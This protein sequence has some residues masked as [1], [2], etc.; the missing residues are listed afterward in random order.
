MEVHDRK[1]VSS[2]GVGRFVCKQHLVVLS[3]TQIGRYSRPGLGATWLCNGSSYGVHTCPVPL[4]FTPTLPSC[5][6]CCPRWLFSQVTVLFCIFWCF[7]FSPILI[8]KRC[9][10]A[11]CFSPQIPRPQS[12]RGCPRQANGVVGECHDSRSWV[13]G[14]VFCFFIIHSIPYLCWR[15]VVDECHCRHPKP[16]AFCNL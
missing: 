5:C 1:W 14:I 6:C 4:F 8:P 2:R 12:R 7:S 13:P 16:H 9:D 10:E 3:R 11:L 15:S